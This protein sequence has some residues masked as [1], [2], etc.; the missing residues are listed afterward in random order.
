LGGRR[1]PLEVRI[2]WRGEDNAAQRLMSPASPRAVAAASNTAAGAGG[3]RGALC[4]ER[5]PA[6]LLVIH[7][8]SFPACLVLR[9]GPERLELHLP[10]LG[11]L[12]LGTRPDS[13]GWLPLR[14]FRPKWLHCGCDSGLRRDTAEPRNGCDSVCTWQATVFGTTSAYLWWSTSRAAASGTCS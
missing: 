12:L 8:A 9:E 4:R 11:W 6:L 5:G 7:F 2:P 14:S 13:R 1:K 10:R 3:A